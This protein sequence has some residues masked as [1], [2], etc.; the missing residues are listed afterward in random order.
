MYKT[1]PI[2]PSNILNF[3]TNANV[4]TQIALPPGKEPAKCVTD[5]RLSRTFGEK[6]NPLQAGN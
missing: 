5:K 6:N 4:L 3:D 1:P 2:T